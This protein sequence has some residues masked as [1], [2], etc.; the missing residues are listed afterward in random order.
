V[1]RFDIEPVEIEPETTATS[2][3]IPTWLSAPV[4]DRLFG[5]TLPFLIS[6]TWLGIVALISE[7][8]L[9]IA[10]LLAAPVLRLLLPFL[11]VTLFKPKLPYLAGGFRN[12]LTLTSQLLCMHLLFA[13]LYIIL[14]VS[15][16]FN[17]VW[18]AGNCLSPPTLVTK[19]I[20]LSFEP[21]VALRSRHCY[22]RESWRAFYHF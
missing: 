17:G 21:T 22:S 15:V 10:S 12:A 1:I 6:L 18:V 14:S 9:P 3:T 5:A 2:E 7:Q 4:W 16:L 11:A 19:P 13:P 8:H 20:P